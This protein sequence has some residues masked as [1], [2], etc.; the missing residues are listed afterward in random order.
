M[1]VCRAVV[2]SRAVVALAALTSAAVVVGCGSST[3]GAVSVP[4]VA[5][6]RVFAL[7]GFRPAGPVFAGRS[8]T[9]SFTIQTPSSGPLTDYKKCC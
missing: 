3:G 6:A 5:P 1:N 7:A 4:T 8:T 2:S 9:V